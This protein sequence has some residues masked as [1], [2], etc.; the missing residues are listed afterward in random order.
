MLGTI[1]TPA[2]GETQ[3]RIQ[4]VSMSFGDVESFIEPPTKAAERKPLQPRHADLNRQQAGEFTPLLKSAVK[5]NR[6]IDMTYENSGLTPVS[7]R[8]HS[9][10]PQNQLALSLRTDQPDDGH[11]DA[12]VSSAVGDAGIREQEKHMDKLKKENWELKLKVFLM[13]KQIYQSSPEHVQIA[14][15][16]NIANKVE[17]AA[18]SLEIQ[19]YKKLLADT[20]GKVALMAEQVS[21]SIIQPE[22]QL[23][24]GMSDAE[25]AKMD[26]LASERDDALAEIKRLQDEADAHAE[27]EGDLDIMTQRFNDAVAATRELEEDHE[28]MTEELGQVRDELEDLK[29]EHEIL[30]TKHDELISQTRSA[31]DDELVQVLREQ[32]EE[33]HAELISLQ[34]RAQT[35]ERRSNSLEE[36]NDVLEAEHEEL[37][38]KTTMLEMQLE[39]TNAERT[40]LAELRESLERQLAEQRDEASHLQGQLADRSFELQQLRDRASPEDEQAARLN[41]LNA[42]KHDLASEVADLAQKVDDLEADLEAAMI[43]DEERDAEVEALQR[44]VEIAHEHLAHASKE[45]SST[46][47]ELAK[48]QAESVTEGERERL[49]LADIVRIEADV[50]ERDL[51]LVALQTELATVNSSLRQKDEK[52]AALETSLLSLRAV[53]AEA[54]TA[55]KA[56]LKAAEQERTETVAAATRQYTEIELQLA[57]Q[58]AAHERKLDEARQV[59]IKL[60]RDLG[61]SREQ[62]QSLEATIRRLGEQEETLN[63]DQARWKDAL[64]MERVRFDSR[65]KALQDQVVDLERARDAARCEVHEAAEAHDQLMMQH[66]R[67]EQI[68]DDLERECQRLKL[69][70][71]EAAT[72][73]ETSTAQRV[74]LQDS[75]RESETALAKVQMDHA[76]AMG[77]CADL[78]ARLAKSEGE[79]GALHDKVA[80]AENECARLSLALESADARVMAVTRRIEEASEERQRLETELENALEQRPT[81]ADDSLAESER[82][83]LRAELMAVK[84]D[85]VGAQTE[86][87]ELAAERDLLELQLDEATSGLEDARR[88]SAESVESLT[89]ELKEIA[90]RLLREQQDRQTEMR[91]AEQA[92]MEAAGRCERLES[93]LRE[94]E[95]AI[96]TERH[97]QTQVDQEREAMR[98]QIATLEDALSRAPSADLPKRFDDQLR[99]LGALQRERAELNRDLDDAI[100]RHAVLQEDYEL[101]EREL[102]SKIDGLQTSVRVSEERHRAHT[103]G[104]TRMLRFVQNAREKQAARAQDLTFIKSFYDRQISSFEACNQANLLIVRQIGIT[105][106]GARSTASPRHGNSPLRLRAVAAAV[107]ASIRLRSIANAAAADR[108]ERHKL[109]RA[110]RVQNGRE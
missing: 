79:L 101:T 27:L 42:E 14:L 35:I 34:N 4:E 104:L 11:A 75:L 97:A 95:S 12:S 65:E 41:Q 60:E 8:Q 56:E 29:L 70:I 73:V 59:R 47:E 62:M 80:S 51:Q 18:L 92:R 50:K 98:L 6:Q 9:N 17:L 20:E 110:A 85:L 106:G 49:R 33:R 107:I 105:A 13:E 55:H 57:A 102:Q 3:R 24:H 86:A 10:H 93:D 40:Q 25:R 91:H 74:A 64:Q 69:E 32:L 48:G 96:A 109:E 87:S 90:E 39:R 58:S 108:A 82:V 78:K 16:E 36:R 76:T 103:A 46:R 54:S 43:R 31:D 23:E 19:K 63:L 21:Q 100:N 15:K 94:L 2:R 52:A 45:L 38:V 26:A 89:R 5:R 61:V 1:A 66:R 84:E 71:F 37:S 7:F 53:H 83:K 77:E 67:L 72:T 30:A 44:E 68:R 88:N 99:E 22:C 81:S 28:R